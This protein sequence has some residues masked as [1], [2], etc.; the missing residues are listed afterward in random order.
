VL[1]LRP[2]SLSLCSKNKEQQTK[3]R[4]KKKEQNKRMNFAAKVGE[5]SLEG[6]RYG[7]VC[8]GDG[9]EIC[10]TLCEESKSLQGHLRYHGVEGQQGHAAE[11]FRS[12]L[13]AMEGEGIQKLQFEATSALLPE[14]F[15]RGKVIVGMYCSICL[16]GFVSEQGFERHRST[17]HHFVDPVRSC[18][19]QPQPK[20]AA[21]SY[22]S[23]T[24]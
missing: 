7:V 18:L 3:K 19:Q 1:V 8:V 17:A 6:S 14:P 5:L 9:P 2:L 22:S 15:P 4:Q 16:K 24:K 12:Y 23:R 21:S 13:A 20:R 10:G 11:I